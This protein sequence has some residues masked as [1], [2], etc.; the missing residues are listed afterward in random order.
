VAVRDTEKRHA[1]RAESP[2]MRSGSNPQ[3]NGAATGGKRRHNQ[4]ILEGRR[5]KG[6][7][8]EKELREA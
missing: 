6:A 4:E 3:E 1:E 8:G 7:R 5:G 2:R